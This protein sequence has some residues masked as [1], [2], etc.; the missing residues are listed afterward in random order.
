MYSTELAPKC[1][2]IKQPLLLSCSWMSALLISKFKQLSSH[3]KHTLLCLFLGSTK[4]WVVPW[5]A[6]PVWDKKNRANK[7]NVFCSP[8]CTF[9]MLWSTAQKGG[10]CG[11]QQRRRPNASSGWSERNSNVHKV[12][13]NFCNELWKPRHRRTQ[14]QL[15]SEETDRGNRLCRSAKRR[16]ICSDNKWLSGFNKQDNSSGCHS[17]RNT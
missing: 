10:A 12:T 13:A 6:A 7:I 14:L 4:E 8:I 16:C 5:A 17:D 11:T 9:K 3:P 1:T 15:P 2:L